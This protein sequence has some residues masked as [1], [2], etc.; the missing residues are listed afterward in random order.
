MDGDRGQAMPLLVIVVV[1][2]ASVVLAVGLVGVRLVHLQ[3][4]HGGADAA[5]LAALDGGRAAAEQLC[6]R[7]GC[8]VVAVISSGHEV[9]VTVDVAGVR[10]SARA[11]WSAWP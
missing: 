2:I 5:A 9:F 8:R 4:A 6:R 3:Q 11:A 1:L 7:N 10:V